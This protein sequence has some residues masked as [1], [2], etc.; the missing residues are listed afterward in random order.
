M[1][2][3]LISSLDLSF[4]WP[5][6]RLKFLLGISAWV[7]H[8]FCIGYSHTEVDP[9]SV[10]PAVFVLLLLTAELFKWASQNLSA[11]LFL[12]LI[13]CILLHLKQILC[14]TSYFFAVVQVTTL[15][16]DSSGVSLSLGSFL[17]ASVKCHCNMLRLTPFILD[18]S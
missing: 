10:F 9:I 6:L 16:S 4:E 1:V 2:L 17:G 15:Y 12:G 18:T 7:L 8:V 3:N 13:F 14:L 5:I 11:C